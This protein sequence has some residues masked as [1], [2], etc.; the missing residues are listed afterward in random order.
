MRE[1]Q[2][3][4]KLKSCFFLIFAPYF[5]LFFKQ[6]FS[7]GKFNHRLINH[8]QKPEKNW[9]EKKTGFL[10]NLPY[11]QKCCKRQT[12]PGK[13]K[14]GTFALCTSVAQ[15]MKNLTNKESGEAYSKFIRP[16][17]RPKK[18][19]SSMGIY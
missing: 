18:R 17:A 13:K 1:S 10:L 4:K 9:R 12:F 8:F 2:F 19:G 14:Y 15:L 16:A 7:P 11:F 3:Q 5:V 6:F